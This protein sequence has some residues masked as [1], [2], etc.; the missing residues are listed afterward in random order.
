MNQLIES[1]KEKTELK[2]AAVYK[3]LCIF[4]AQQLGVGNREWGIGKES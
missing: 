1:P 2:E 3:L 4:N